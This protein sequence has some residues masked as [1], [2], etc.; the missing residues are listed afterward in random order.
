MPS[1][2]AQT[3][4]Y[5]ETLL[6]FEVCRSDHIRVEARVVALVAFSL[7]ASI[8][9]VWRVMMGYHTMPQ[10]IVGALLGCVFGSTWFT[11]YPYIEKVYRFF[12]P[13]PVIFQF[14]ATA[15]L[16]GTAAVVIERSL[17]KRLK[18]AAKTTK[19]TL[20]TAAKHTQKKLEK[21]MLGK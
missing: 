21:R 20:E 17:Q 1:S 7:F 8:S 14:L 19:K 13:Y 12:G 3:L 9:S 4:F 10:V 2:H 5:Y 6:L 18:R 16:I 11:L 15:G